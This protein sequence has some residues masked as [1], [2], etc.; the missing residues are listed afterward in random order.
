[1]E[2]ANFLIGK[3]GSLNLWFIL[4]VLLGF[5]FSFLFV[6]DFDLVFFYWKVPV[7]SY[8]SSF[9]ETDSVMILAYNMSMTGAVVSLLRVRTADLMSWTGTKEKSDCISSCSCGEALV[10]SSRVDLE[11]K[12]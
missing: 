1:M 4:R 11:L 8:S 7:A 9:S 3:V 12:I 6:P 10:D 5:S 2:L